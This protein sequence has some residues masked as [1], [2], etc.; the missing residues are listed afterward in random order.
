MCHSSLGI[1]ERNHMKKA[2]KSLDREQDDSRPS[3][4]LGILSE[5]EE[6]DEDIIDLEDIIELGLEEK[7]AKPDADEEILDAD[8]ELDLSALDVDQDDREADTLEADLLK[9]FG[10]D[11]TVE[12]EPQLEQESRSHGGD[13]GGN[14]HSGTS[15]KEETGSLEGLDSDLDFLLKDGEKDDFEKLLDMGDDK[16]V[17]SS[18]GERLPA[19]LETKATAA[20]ISEEV[21]VMA[22]PYEFRDLDELIDQIESKLNQT[23][24]EIVEARLPDI[25]RTL[26]R[27][28]I[29]NLKKDFS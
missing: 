22:E 23:I 2:K 3:R 29:E 10:F 17:G 24:R 4:N 19:G 1:C 28:E 18:G 21:P 20:S 11:E 8:G 15:R 7:A 9:E 6:L 25:V 26:L 5:E 14:I 13:K 16:K 12:L 27:E